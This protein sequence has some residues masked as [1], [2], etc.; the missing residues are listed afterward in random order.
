MQ[1]SDNWIVRPEPLDVSTVQGVGSPSLG[2]WGCLAPILVLIAAT[3]IG[4][5]ID[6]P[7][8]LTLVPAALFVG[9]LFYVD[10]QRQ[11]ARLTSEY[12]KRLERERHR[13]VSKAESTTERSI[14]YLQQGEELTST[15]RLSLEKANRTLSQAEHEFNERAFGPFWDAVETAAVELGKYRDGLEELARAAEWYQQGLSKTNH[16]FPEW[17]Q[18]VVPPGAPSST[19]LRFRAIVR[20]G[21]TDYEFSSILEQRLT[22]EVLIR[23][24]KHLGEALSGL[25]QIV[26]SKFSEMQCRIEALSKRQ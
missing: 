19:L 21:Q 12:H 7:W 5:F 22:R 8:I 14:S 3:V 11:G 1:S 25:N 17:Q 2:Y 18:A 4:A 13:L 6:W 10:S 9:A 16:T 26:E 23:G 20:R 15:L 24:F